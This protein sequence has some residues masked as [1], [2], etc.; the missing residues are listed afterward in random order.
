MPDDHGESTSGL[1]LEVLADWMDQRA[2]ETGPITDVTELTGG[3]QNLMVRF[4][5]SDR[6][7]V[8][9]RQPIHK[10]DTSDETMRREARVLAALKD[11]DVPHPSLIASEA[12][13]DVL[14]AA[15]YLM[16]PIDGFNPA[17]G[18]PELHAGSPEMRRAMRL[19][20]ADA[21]AA[22]AR[23]DYVAAG[24]GDFGRPAGYLDRQVGRWRAQL[25]TYASISPTWTPEI[26][27]LATEV[28]LHA[29]VVGCSGGERWFD[30]VRV[31]HVQFAVERDRQHVIGC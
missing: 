2:L 31:G 15:F 5:R 27:G 3:T 19:S 30:P 23:V 16:E 22:I 9:R 18:L 8:L 11:S 13:V 25:D 4:R 12:D 17:Q 14:G 6:E 29:T 28:D 24:L 21:L 26:P 10:R 7:F 20:L 1:D